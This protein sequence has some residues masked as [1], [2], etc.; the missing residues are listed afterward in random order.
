MKPV[1]VSGFF[2]PVKTWKIKF[3]LTAAFVTVLSATAVRAQQLKAPDLVEVTQAQKM[4]AHGALL[5]DVRESDEYD[6]VH[7]PHAKLIPLGQLSSRLAEIADFKDRP[8]EVICHSGARSQKAL[9]LL[10]EVGFSRV[11]SV[12]GG[13]VAW[14]KAG[15]EVIKH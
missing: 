9:K 7:A 3:I 6:E 1:T 5:L 11:S 4:S 12:A 15:L 13:M 10:Q 8:V 14:E 2:N